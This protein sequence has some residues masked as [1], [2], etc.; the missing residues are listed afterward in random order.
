[1]AAFDPAKA[2]DLIG[3]FDLSM[4]DTTSLRGGMHEHSGRLV[5][6][7]Q[8]S[9]PRRRASMAKAVHQ[10][11][12]V[13]FFEAALPD[14]GDMWSSMRERASDA[15]GVFWADGFLRLG[16]FGPKSGISLYVHTMGP[17]ELR[18]MW[19][20]HAGTAIIVDFTGER[21]PDEA[22]YFCARRV[23]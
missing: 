6:L 4:V 21:E 13:G 18:G 19:T 2:G 11:F 23:K 9:V 5:L 1:M 10:K 7:F 20:S 3:T 14:T 17:D 15:P 12:I 16:E 8:D 22:G